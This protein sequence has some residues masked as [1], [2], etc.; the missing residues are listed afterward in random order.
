M[1][2]VFVASAVA[3]Y[4]PYGDWASVEEKTKQNDL[5]NLG[6]KKKH[7]EEKGAWERGWETFTLLLL[8]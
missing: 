3:G 1:Q 4:T 7:V 5:S 8:L 6:E 2:R